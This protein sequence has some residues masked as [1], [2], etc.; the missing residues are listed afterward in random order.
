MAQTL[1][2]VRAQTFTDFVVD[3]GLEPDEPAA[4]LEACAP[5]LEDP[6][7]RVKLNPERLGWDKN[8]RA[9]LRRVETPYFTILPHDDVM[10]P[11]YLASLLAALRDR[12]EVSVAHSD[13]VHFGDDIHRKWME[14]PD[15]AVGRRMLSF[16]LQ[17]AEGDLWRGVT[18]STVLRREHPV[19]DYQGFAVETEW[20]LHL[21]QSGLTARVARPLYLKRVQSSTGVAFGWTALGEER[22]RDALEWHRGRMLGDVRE[23]GLEPEIGGLVTLAAEA[24][25]FKRWVSFTGGHITPTP[26]EEARVEHLIH[27]ARDTGAPEGRQ[28]LAMLL[29]AQS[30]FWNDRGDPPRSEE[31]ARAATEACPTD[32]EALLHL[33]HL[34]L[35]RRQ[36]HEALE[37]LLAVSVLSPMTRGVHNLTREAMRQLASIY[38]VP[39]IP[40]LPDKGG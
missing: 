5:F 39:P 24:A 19:N 16:F 32:W 36:P 1:G 17:G 25:M 38:A 9:L 34:L 40:A 10:H 22:L 30:M 28:I 23:A 3:V 26:E 31:L 8:V 15:A 13:K 37:L 35:D 18:R 21:V 29:L 4:T 11:E 33:A 27:E 7:F 14:I 6:R 20:S 12:P 2:S